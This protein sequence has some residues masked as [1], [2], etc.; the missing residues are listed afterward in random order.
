MTDGI[1]VE[2]CCCESVLLNEIAMKEMHQK[3]IAQT[4]RLALESSERDSIDW[5]KV[6]NAIIARW[7]KSGLNRI[8]ELA[9]SGKAFAK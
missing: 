2:L 5:A 4:Y 9:W 8:K 1:K 6:N 3:Q 7:S